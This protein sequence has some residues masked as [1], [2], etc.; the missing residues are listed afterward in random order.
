MKVAMSKQLFADR[1]EAAAQLLPLL[2]KYRRSDS[3]VVLGLPRGGVVLAA[4]IAEGLS[5]PLDVIIVKKVTPPHNDEFA[6]GAVTEDGES[7]FDWT[8]NEEVCGPQRAFEVVIDKRRQEAAARAA[9]Y[10]KILP[11]HDLKGKTAILVDDG[12]ATGTTMRAAMKAARVRGAK[13]IVV[14]VPVS[15]QDSLAQVRGD[16]DEVAC[17]HTID[18]FAAVGQCYKE[19][20]QI[21]DAQVITIL[22]RFSAKGA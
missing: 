8:M 6:V 17:P 3:A 13:K 4:K 9:H 22:K 12:I 15:P 1:E 21:E 11:M 14:A 18:F 19:F 10:R 2:E 5:L 16:A 20:P 7:F